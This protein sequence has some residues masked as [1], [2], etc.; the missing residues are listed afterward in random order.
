MQH[1][2]AEWCTAQGAKQVQLE[3]SVERGRADVRC[4]LRGVVYSVEVQRSPIHPEEIDRRSAL[5]AR[6]GGV[7]VWLLSSRVCPDP[8]PARPLLLAH[9]ITEAG[10][11]LRLGDVYGFRSP[12]FFLEECKLHAHQGV[13]HPVWSA[14]A[15]RRKE[16]ARGADASGSAS[17]HGG[18][19]K[20][21]GSGAMGRAAAS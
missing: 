1:R 10:L 19:E 2:V 7:V 18:P 12:E 11:R 14:G 20:S 16:A 13:S 21:R 9:T 3:V 15:N 8:V 17:T 5:Y 6:D 4:V